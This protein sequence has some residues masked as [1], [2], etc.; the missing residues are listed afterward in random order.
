MKKLLLATAFTLAMSASAMATIVGN[1]G[2]NPTSQFGDFSSGTLG[3]NGT[4]SGLFSDDFLFQL[5]GGPQFL[6]IASATNVFPGGSGTSDFIT[7]FSAS[8]FSY[9]PDNLFGGGDDQLVLGPANATMGCGIIVNCQGMA[10]IALLDAGN[11]Y[12]EFSGTGGGSSGYGGNIATFAEA[13]TPL[14]AAVWLFGSALGGGAFLLR[15]RRKKQPEP[16][17]A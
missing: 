12:L 1:L 6:T 9:G 4:G 15:R 7:N 8:V 14:P 13:E 11:Y 10:G 16:L 3:V 17:A 2:V 5:V